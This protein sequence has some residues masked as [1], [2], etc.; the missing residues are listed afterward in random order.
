M[1]WNKR[2]DCHVFVGNINEGTDQFGEKRTSRHGRHA[3]FDDETYE[4]SAILLNLVARRKSD[5]TLQSV[6]LPILSIMV[7]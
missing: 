6:G 1:M 5:E 2:D 3:I 7:L 4:T